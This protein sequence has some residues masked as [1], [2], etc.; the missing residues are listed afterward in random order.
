LREECRLRVFKNRV[1]RRIFGPKND[2]V[3][4]EWRRLHKKELYVLYFSSNII[5]VQIKKTEIC[6]RLTHVGERRGAYMVLVWKLEGRRL[7]GR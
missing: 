3:T 1:L 4:G 6:G 5:R 2:A 7:R